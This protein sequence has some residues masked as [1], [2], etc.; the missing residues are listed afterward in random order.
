MKSNNDTVERQFRGR[1][2][3]RGFL[4]AETG[5]HIGA[6]T[7]TMEIQGI[8]SPVVRDPM[9][10]EPYIPGSSLKGKCRAL[11]ERYISVKAGEGSNF[12]KRTMQTKPEIRIH[13][14]ESAAKAHSCGVCRLFGSSA[15]RESESP[16]EGQVSNF[17]ARLRFRDAFVPRYVLRKLEPT[18]LLYTEIK[19]ENV[20]DRLTAAAMPRQIER[21]PAGTDFCIEIVYDVEDLDQI[22]E[23]LRHLQYCLSSLEDDAIGGHGSRGYGRVKVY[24]TTLEARR[25]DWY[26]Q[27]SGNASGD[28]GSLVVLKSQEV[29]RETK[30]EPEDLSSFARPDIIAEKASEI[31]SFF[32]KGR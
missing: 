17:P 2:I 23:D 16:G 3:I 10:K 11:L 9:T 20:L 12:F 7:E 21:V 8:D 31:R 14:C 32:E 13:V 4:R 26:L 5:I 1:V 25:A 22:E 6:G 18:D 28:N 24:L 19:S 30:Q 15:A 27:R 29:D